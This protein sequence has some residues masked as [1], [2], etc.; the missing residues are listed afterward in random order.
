M[1]LITDYLLD[2]GIYL[3]KEEIRNIQTYSKIQIGEKN[4][5]RYG[6]KNGK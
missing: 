1:F 4:S 5:M 6:R 3:L 2:N